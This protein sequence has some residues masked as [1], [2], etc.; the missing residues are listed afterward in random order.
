MGGMSEKIMELHRIGRADGIESICE[1]ISSLLADGREE[2]AGMLIA[3]GR[4]LEAVSADLANLDGIL[5]L[6]SGDVEGAAE[7]FTEAVLIDGGRADLY[8][9]L[10]TA[11]LEGGR[12]KEAA[13]AI[14]SGLAIDGGNINLLRNAASA[15]IILGDMDR[16][17]ELAC[18]AVSEEPFEAGSHVVHA[19]TLL[20]SGDRTGAAEALERIRFLQAIPVKVLL[21]AVHLY[22]RMDMLEEAEGAVYAALEVDPPNLKLM[23]LLAK[24]LEMRTDLKGAKHVYVTILSHDPENVDARNG[25]GCV[26]ERNGEYIE[27]LEHFLEAHRLLPSSDQIEVNLAVVMDKLDMDDEAERHLAVVMERAPMFGAAFNAMG[28]FLSRRGR[29]IE[30]ETNFSAAIELEPANEGYLHNLSLARDMIKA[31]GTRE[32]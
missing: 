14:A 2:E 10:G 8:N 30:A 22:I 29:Y 21:K 5:C 18:R 13:E 19:E 1:R 26:L 6:R 32:D 20:R 24:I 11:L 23:L 28:C 9:N 17:V 27:A 7:R 3:E 16:A 12:V 25:L 31:T 4:R 15:A